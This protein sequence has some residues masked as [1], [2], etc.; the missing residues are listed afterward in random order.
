MTS[1]SWVHRAQSAS[2][3]LM[4]IPASIAMR[5]ARVCRLVPHSPRSLVGAASGIGREAA[6]RLGAAGP[7]LILIGRDR[8]RGDDQPLADPALHS[9]SVAAIARSCGYPDARRF[10]TAFRRRWGA[11]PTEVRARNGTTHLAEP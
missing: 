7:R 10:S 3:S 8:R 6:L 1:V 2:A 9:L 5:V 4:R 11:L